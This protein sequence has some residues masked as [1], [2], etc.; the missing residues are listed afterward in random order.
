MFS[1]TIAAFCWVDQL[2]LADRL[3]DL[4]EAAILVGGGR[5]DVADQLVDRRDVVV[6]DGQRFAGFLHQLDAAADL[7]RALGNQSLDLAG[8]TGAALGQLA[9]FLCDDREATAGITG[10]GRLDAGVQC[11]E[12]GLESDLVDDADDR[13]IF[14]DDC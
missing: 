7:R 1:S 6:D 2:D 11:Q 14:S 3:V 9:H 8:S 12:I 5:F 13:A 4:V 10:A